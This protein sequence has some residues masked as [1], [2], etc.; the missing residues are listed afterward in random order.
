MK[1]VL[2]NVI[3]I[4]KCSLNNIFQD[5]FIKISSHQLT[6]DR[7]YIL[8]RFKSHKSDSIGE[9]QTACSVQSDLHLYCPQ[10]ER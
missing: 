10:K 9:G 3:N 6:C 2:K 4:A 1:L 5:S 8:I 7:S